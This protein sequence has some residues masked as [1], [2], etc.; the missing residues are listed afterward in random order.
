MSEI[1]QTEDSKKKISLQEAMKQQLLNKKNK[2]TSGNSNVNGSS[3]TQKMR[4]QQ[5]KK[6]SNSRRK[7]GV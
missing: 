3:A 5:T 4:S 2:A 6:V 1:N 7:M